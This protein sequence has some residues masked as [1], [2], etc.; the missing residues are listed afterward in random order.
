M[1]HLQSTS[2]SSEETYL[3]Q[4]NSKRVKE[5]A[6]PGHMESVPGNNEELPSNLLKFSF[7]DAVRKS[8][9]EVN[10]GISFR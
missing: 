7:V 10:K 6:N 1:T 8:G 2:L 4:R 3:L 9:S 5:H